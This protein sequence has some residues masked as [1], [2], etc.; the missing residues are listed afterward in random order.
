MDIK[1][2]QD[3]PEPPVIVELTKQ[4]VKRLIERN[5]SF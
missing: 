2:E 5:K 1:Y 4:A 3:L